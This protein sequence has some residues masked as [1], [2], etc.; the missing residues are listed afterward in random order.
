MKKLLLLFLTFCLMLTVL[1]GCSQRLPTL[2]VTFFDVGKGDC[3]LLECDGHAAMIDA[4]FDN[5]A[6]DILSALA[7]K[8]IDTLDFLLLTHMDKDHVGGADKFL[9]NLTIGAVYAPDYEKDAKQYQQYVD[10]LA[11]SGMTAIH[12]AEPLTLSFAQALSVCGRCG[13]CA[14]AGI[15]IGHAA[16]GGCTQGTAP[17]PLGRAFGRFLQGCDAAL[18]SHHL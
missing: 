14:F 3:I 18:R 11:A 7:D 9:E 16:H 10:A 17:R 1:S 8:G 4:G 12:P 13:E 5:T 6:N 2:T 15:S